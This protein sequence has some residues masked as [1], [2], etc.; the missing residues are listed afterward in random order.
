MKNKKHDEIEPQDMPLA[1]SAGH[2]TDMEDAL[3]RF[4]QM[5][6]TRK[7]EAELVQRDKD[8]AS[9]AEILAQA[10]ALVGDTFDPAHSREVHALLDRLK[11]LGAIV[12]DRRD[13]E[14]WRVERDEAEVAAA[15]LR[16]T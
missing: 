4:Q 14:R 13:V 1:L 5:V 15:C 11:E 9:V 3:A 8:R 12:V 6:Q 16:K 2:V 7:A 10:Y